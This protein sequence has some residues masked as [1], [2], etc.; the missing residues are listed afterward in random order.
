[1]E[2]KTKI[3]VGAA[4]FYLIIPFIIFVIGWMKIWIAVPMVIL[5]LLCFYKMICHAPKL[6]CPKFTRENIIKMMIILA[7]I[8]IWVY[9]S[10][11][12]KLVFQNSDHGARNAIFDVLVQYDWPIRGLSEQGQT[13]SLIYYIGFWIPAA[14]V[15][16]VLGLQAGYLMQVVWAILGITLVYYFICTRTKKLE[17]WPLFILVF[18]SG[19]DYLG[20]LFL[21]TDMSTIGLTMHLEWWN[22]PYQL[23]SMTTQLFW[24]FNQCIPAWLATILLL[25]LKDNKSIVII[26]ATTMLTS[27]LPFVGLLPIIIYLIF[28]KK[29]NGEKKWTAVFW[30]NIFTLENVVGGGII[31]IT[32]FL[33]LCGN[34]SGGMLG[35]SSQA[36]KPNGK[37][38]SVLLW[39][40]TVLLEVGIYI[41]LVYRKERKNPLF[42]II[43]A[44]LCLFP[45]I[46]VGTS[47]DFCMRAVIP[48]QVILM[49]YVIDLLRDAALQKKRLLLWVTIITL[50]IGSIT[51]IHELTRTLAQTVILRREQKPVEAEV[52]NEEDLLQPGNFAGVTEDDFFNNYLA[53]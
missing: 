44:E 23:S 1:M 8:C 21:G 18:F 46:R 42:Y 37:D 19:L 17:I 7:G 49:L 48:A 13:T 27:T 6:W 33:Y 9:F 16:K 3:G 11:I 36:I 45:L 26:W 30:K 15:G 43:V 24:V 14:A 39:F 29:Y 52:V 53:K 12:G 20:Y 22:D 51:P 50:G 28:F 40:L 32:S 10:G 47:N 5:L 38:G 41:A 2:K 25:N 35:S 31:G 34:M 4:Y